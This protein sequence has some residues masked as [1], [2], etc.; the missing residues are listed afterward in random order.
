M[1]LNKQFLPKIQKYKV[2]FELPEEQVEGKSVKLLGDFN[3]W[4]VEEARE[5][6]LISGV[7][8]IYY[9]LDAGINYEYRFLVD[10]KN[11]INDQIADDYVSTQFPGVKNGV[12]RLEKKS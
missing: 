3:N 7:Y 11:W 8:K 5:L 1:P 6:T 4:D 10:D 9:E 12:V 2:A